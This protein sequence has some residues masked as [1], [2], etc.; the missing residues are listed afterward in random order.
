MAEKLRILVVDD[1]ET[2]CNLLR[3]CLSEEGYEVSITQ[4]AEDGL[5]QIRN[6]PFDLIIT[7]LKMPGIDGI[8]FIRQIRGFDADYMVIVITAYPTFETV[9]DAL[10]LGAY[11][12]ATKPVNLEELSFMVKKASDFYH[13]KL[14]N[15]KLKEELEQKNIALEKKVAEGDKAL[16]QI[17]TDVG[18]NKK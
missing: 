7:D 9:R 12:Y 18:R 13:L 14:A 11:D 2:I 6:S 5:S 4:N 3:D 10:R 8:E 16:R 15:K 17:I 1:E